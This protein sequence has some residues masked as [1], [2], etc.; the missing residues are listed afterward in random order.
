MQNSGQVEHESRIYYKRTC[1]LFVPGLCQCAL[2]K[3][4][5]ALFLSSCARLPKRALALQ[6]MLMMPRCP[7]LG[8][9][10]HRQHHAHQLGAP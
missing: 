10:K 9:A 2:E 8:V 4:G 3:S 7:L 1:C 6:L 5:L